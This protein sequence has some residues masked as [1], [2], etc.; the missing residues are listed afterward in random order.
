MDYPTF[1]LDSYF[2]SGKPCLTF[3]IENI[4]H[5]YSHDNSKFH[6]HDYFEI[7]FFIKGGAKHIIEFES[8]DIEDKSVS[9]VFPRQFHRLI[10]NSE[11]QGVVL[12]FNE[13][14]FCSEML[15]KEL[16]AYFVDI[17]TRLNYLRPNL[18]NF[19]EVFQ[20]A[21]MIENMFDNLNLFKKEQIRHM[22]KL[23]ILSLMDYTKSSILNK[24]EANDSNLF[25][26]YI[27]LVDKNYKEYRLVSD[28]TIEL[29]LS[30]KKINA[31]SK[32]YRGQTA[33]QIIHDRIL[34]EAK[35]MLSFS[36]LS[37]KDIAYSLNFD[38]PAAFNK[39]IH[40]KTNHSPTELQKLLTDIHRV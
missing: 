16:R 33:L 18:E 6:R 26:E 22:I 4:H 5:N 19:D 14:V 25:I 17:Q 37:H 1:T 24:V 39:F 9:V 15:Q 20:I 23:I 35:R 8:Y 40:A 36:G 12:M 11:T 30:S 29:G 38:S 13:E 7:Y 2:E 10:L 21:N 34:L 32:K 28:Y 27:E 3:N 31:L